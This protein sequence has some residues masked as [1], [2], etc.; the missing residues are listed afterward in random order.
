M[1]SS[2]MYPSCQEADKDVLARIPAQPCENRD[3]NEAILRFWVREL[4]MSMM[5]AG[6]KEG[7]AGTKYQRAEVKNCSRDKIIPGTKAKIAV[8]P[9]KEAEQDD[10]DIVRCFEELVAVVSADVYQMMNEYT[11][12]R[13]V[14]YLIGPMLMILRYA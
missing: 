10:R 5:D 4:Q 13:L 7:A 14:T 12:L 9:K 8:N 3:A 6:G 1:Y 11:F 2:G